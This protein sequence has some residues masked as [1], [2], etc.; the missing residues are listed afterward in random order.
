MG[1][2]P[3][4]RKIRQVQYPPCYSYFKSCGVPRR[5]LAQIELTLD[6][7]EAL[8]LVDEQGLDQEAAAELLQIS[9]PIV[10]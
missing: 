8:R 5:Q 4:P 2:M 9:R 3:K 10:T 6:E 1:V 7:Y